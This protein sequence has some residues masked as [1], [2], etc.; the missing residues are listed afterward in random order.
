[1]TNKSGHFQSTTTQRGQ[2]NS[3]HQRE[4]YPFPKYLNCFETKQCDVTQTAPITH[5]EG[6]SSSFCS[7]CNQWQQNKTGRFDPARLI[8]P[9]RPIFY[10]PI[11]FSHQISEKAAIVPIKRIIGGTS[12]LGTRRRLWGPPCRPNTKDWGPGGRGAL[13]WSR[14]PW[15]PWRMRPWAAHWHARPRFTIPVKEARDGLTKEVSLVIWPSLRSSDKGERTN[16][17]KVSSRQR[18]TDKSDRTDKEV[19]AEVSGHLVLEN[20]LLAVKSRETPDSSIHQITSETHC[21]IVNKPPISFCGQTMFVGNIWN[22]FYILTPRIRDSCS[23]S[24]TK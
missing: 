9:S 16:E 6:R 8:K 10:H 13:V 4:L 17:T 3:K 1:M 23:C 24:V 15:G 12:K 21:G 20:M 22:T 18:W 11:Q 2:Q 7:P 19:T 14:D 5:F